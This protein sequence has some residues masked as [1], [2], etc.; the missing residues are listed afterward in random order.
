MPSKPLATDHHQDQLT[1]DGINLNYPVKS[2][3]AARPMLGEICEEIALAILPHSKRLRVH[4]G[5]LC[6]DIHIN[7]IDGGVEMY[8]EVKSVGQTG[9]SHL[10]KSRIEKYVEKAK[11]DSTFGLVYIFV[12]HNAKWEEGD[13]RDSL[14]RKVIQTMSRILFVN[15]EKM[16]HLTGYLPKRK[17]NIKGR[18][19]LSSVYRLTKNVLN[20]L[21][22]LSGKAVCRFD[23]YNAHCAIPLGQVGDE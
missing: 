15:G 5:R 4:S 7:K 6:P 12:F 22:V 13:T 14:R 11:E 8:G 19:E 21:W 20:V 16:H 18:P 17:F 10:F 1:I 9:A 3:A 2:S 23:I